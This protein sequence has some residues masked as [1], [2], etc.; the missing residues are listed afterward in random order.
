MQAF[1]AEPSAGLW[2]DP[3]MSGL[4][5]WIEAEA[6]GKASRHQ[7]DQKQIFPQCLSS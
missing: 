5:S 4:G 6:L 1:S 2:N 3:A 7:E